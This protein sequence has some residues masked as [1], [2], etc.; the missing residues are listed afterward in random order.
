MKGSID[1]IRVLL[2]RKLKMEDNGSE[3]KRAVFGKQSKN[4]GGNRTHSVLFYKQ[5][6]VEYKS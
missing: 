5:H 1:K 3:T 2:G 4:G 6:T